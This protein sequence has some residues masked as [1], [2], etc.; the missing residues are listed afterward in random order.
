MSV[1]PANAF[2]SSGA[3]LPKGETNDNQRNVG[4]ARFAR[5]SLLPAAHGG[6]CFDRVRG[7]LRAEGLSAHAGALLTIVVATMTGDEHGVTRDAAQ[8]VDGRRASPMRRFVGLSIDSMFALGRF[9]AGL[10]HLCPRDRGFERLG[11]RARELHEGGKG[12]VFPMH[13]VEAARRSP[14]SLRS[15]RARSLRGRALSGPF[16]YETGRPCSATPST[17]AGHRSIDSTI[18]YGRLPRVVL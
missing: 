7:T 6:M 18:V 1:S 10:H 8:P 5:A 3:R 17:N 2:E 9:A 14:D 12:N 4:R 13:S 16:A 11:S 15:L